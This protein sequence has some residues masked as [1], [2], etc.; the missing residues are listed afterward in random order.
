MTS[1]GSPSTSRR[2]KG[3]KK[4][5]GESCPINAIYYNYIELRRLEGNRVFPIWLKIFLEKYSFLWKSTTGNQSLMIRIF[6]D[7][8]SLTVKLDISIKLLFIVEK[9]IWESCMTVSCRERV[10]TSH[11]AVAGFGWTVRKNLNRQFLIQNVPGLHPKYLC[12]VM[13]AFLL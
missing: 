4:K 1:V 8:Y 3:G 6:V 7:Y 9:Y 13:K 12:N 11:A 2:V 5:Y 10:T